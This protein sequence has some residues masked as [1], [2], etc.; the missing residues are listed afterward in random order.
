MTRSPASGDFLLTKWLYMLPLLH[1][2]ANICIVAYW[3]KTQTIGTLFFILESRMSTCGLSKLAENFA[4]P[5][6][7]LPRYLIYV[8]GF[9]HSESYKEILAE[10]GWC[11]ICILWYTR[12]NVCRGYQHWHLI[13]KSNNGDHK[14][15]NQDTNQVNVYSEN[16]N[17]TNLWQHYQYRKYNDNFIK[18]KKLS[19]LWF[20]KIPICQLHN[21]K[22]IPASTPT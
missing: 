13:S 4:V 2:L 21:A 10:N 11:C 15:D 19:C 5:E 17:A 8:S 12:I 22:H 3:Y 7:A 14:C 16:I 20:D 6:L 9:I 18:M 1:V